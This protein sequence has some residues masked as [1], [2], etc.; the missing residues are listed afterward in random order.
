MVTE[1]AKAG[2]LEPIVQFSIF[3]PNRLGR[4]HDLVALLGA[5]NTH[6]LAL[7]VLD[8]TDSAILRIITD[9]PDTARKLLVTEGFPFTES[10]LVVVEAGSTDLTRLMSALLEA[11]LNINYLYPFIPQPGGNSMLALSLEDAE[12]AEQ[13]LVRHQFRV[14][15][16]GDISR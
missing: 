3:T 4:L 15:K 11:E 6:V 10:K 2:R 16:Q 12:L 14:L 7:M 13:T 8:T 9:D 5:H 1:V